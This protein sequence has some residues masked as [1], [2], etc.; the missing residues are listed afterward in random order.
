MS[1]A[2]ELELISRVLNNENIFGESEFGKEINKLNELVNNKYK[3]LVNEGNFF[4]KEESLESINDL[5]L[6]IELLI[7]Y[8]M[9][10]GKNIIGIMADNQNSRLEMTKDII[11]IDEEKFNLFHNRSIPIIYSNGEESLSILNKFDY[12]EEINKDDVEIIRKK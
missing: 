1:S 2:Y 9:L 10:I 4:E 11:G 3:G 5:C 12:V 8:Y 7:K 6:Q